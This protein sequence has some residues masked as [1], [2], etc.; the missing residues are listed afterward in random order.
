M[1]TVNI[2]KYLHTENKGDKINDLSEDKLN[3]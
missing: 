3:S 1:K 2:H